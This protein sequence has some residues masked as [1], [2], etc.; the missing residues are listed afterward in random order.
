ML[1]GRTGTGIQAIWLYCPH[2]GERR[3]V[4]GGLL[5][6]LVKGPLPF[7]ATLLGS[8]TMETHTSPLDLHIPWCFKCLPPGLLS[9]GKDLLNLEP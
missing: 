1:S 3:L 4:G 9:K 5:P 6:L 7:M 2:P 8:V